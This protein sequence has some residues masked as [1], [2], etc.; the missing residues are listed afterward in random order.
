M[1]V[2]KIVVEQ[3]AQVHERLR[4]ADGAAKVWQQVRGIASAVVA[5]PRKAKHDLCLA[6]LAI[7]A[8]VHQKAKEAKDEAQKH[9]V[10][11]PLF[12]Q[13]VPDIC[14]PFFAGPRGLYYSKAGGAVARESAPLS[15][16]AGA[17]VLRARVGA[18]Q[19]F[20]AVYDLMLHIKR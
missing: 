9:E 13:L 15:A 4:E 7:C 11:A 8:N 20:F 14:P 10:N 16:A 17:T 12:V 18:A 2:G 3:R 1:V 19:F 6:P 5:Q